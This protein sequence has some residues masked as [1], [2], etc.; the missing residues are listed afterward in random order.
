MTKKK[1]AAGSALITSGALCHLCP[2]HIGV[3]GGIV[4]STSSFLSETQLGRVGSYMHHKQLDI[5]QK[6]VK[7]FIREEEAPFPPVRSGL[8]AEI[9]RPISENHA[10]TAEN[11]VSTVN[12][13]TITLGVYLIGKSIIDSY[14]KQ[15]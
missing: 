9:Q 13:L 4:G 7:P 8:Y 11:I 12:A 3:Y 5:V 6:I 15:N 2:Y 14:R 10:R 1:T